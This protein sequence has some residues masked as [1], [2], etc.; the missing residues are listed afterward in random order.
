MEQN[1]LLAT[2][3]YI[4]PTRPELVHRPDLINKLNDGL[5]QSDLPKGLHFARK[6]TLIS[7]PAG[8]GKTTLVSE[9]IQAVR[10]D[11]PSVSIAWLS[12]DEGDNDLTRFLSYLIAALNASESLDH[13]FGQETLRMLQS[14]QP[15]S[16]DALLV[17]LINEI[18]AVR[19]QM[20]VIL[21]DY[22][23]IN[24]QTIHDA[25][26]LLIEHL[27]PQL[28]L[29]I[30]TRVDPPLPLARL[31]GRG[32][33]CEFRAVDLRFSLTEA[34]EFL[35]KVM[36]LHLATQDIS[37]LASRTE[38]WIAGL[39]LA[40]ISLQG[41]KNTSILIESFTG[42]HR[43]VMDY[44]VEEVLDQQSENVQTFLLQTSFLDRMSGSLCHA[45]T[46][47]QDSQ[48]ILERLDRA[49]LFIVPLDNKR[50]WYRYHHLFA[51]L[52]RQRLQQAQA[53]NL[54]VLHLRASQWYEQNGF[55]EQSIKHALLGE[56]P[57]RA[58]RLIESIAETLLMRGEII[59]LKSWVDSL[60]Q[61]IVHQ[62]PLLCLYYAGV[63]MLSGE[64]P[65]RI[66]TYLQYSIARAIP[67]TVS[68]GTLVLRALLALWQGDADQSITLGQHALAE[69]PD[70]YLFWR[71]IV[72]GN[73]GIAYMYGGRDID[74]AERMLQRAASMGERVG[75]VIGAVTALCNLAEVH[76][77]RGELRTAKEVYDR[78]L[79]LAVD[80]RGAIL[81]IGGMAITG[82][83][84][85]Q[86][87]WNKLREAEKLLTTAI[88][89][90]DE[91][92]PFWATEGYLVLARVKQS[93]GDIAS[94]NDAIGHAKK[95]AAKTGATELDD[96][97]VDATQAHLWVAQGQLNAAARWAKDRGLIAEEFVFASKE[98]RT[99][100]HS[101]YKLEYLTLAELWIG[102]G[103][104]G[105]ALKLLS[106]FLSESRSLQWTDSVIK[107]LTLTAIAHHQLGHPL[108][109]LDALSEA[110]I[111][112]KRGG[113]KRTFLNSG[114]HI[115]HLLR[116]TL[117]QGIAVDYVKQLLTAFGSDTSHPAE[118]QVRVELLS[119]RELQVLRLLR[120]HLTSAEIAQ[121]LYISAN[122]VRFHTKNIYSKLNVHSRSEAIQ[123]AQEL[124]LL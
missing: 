51:D 58:A 99:L 2:K 123:R 71:G 38:G 57:E 80:D 69:L 87:E 83:A 3:F 5:R 106:P 9:W 35:N 61:E 13:S 47:R 29:V 79:V 53:K 55:A 64:P 44:L 42:S 23:L 7:A 115:V 85:L 89:L 103:N 10:K 63:L 4:P 92:L 22:H 28:H 52:L 1:L 8:F 102:Q 82:I 120:T 73:L 75:S 114:P 20:I 62:H 48:A 119:D 81:P 18:L 54:P 50:Q 46:G 21:D 116:Q 34:A 67:D 109:A 15:P 17:P 25:L 101:L 33:L 65:S 45:V 36:G 72:T 77:I 108:Q 74:T 113:Y 11:V 124:G 60:P 41:H 117:T 19:D 6:L 105:W 110:L 90:T 98:N 39:Q 84:G 93:L 49:N 56:S 16:H 95:R 122:T 24:A 96:M 37:A 32:Q 88:D 31:R 104:S 26:I 70:Q 27:P 78:A 30:T 59:T 68:H 86:L 112:A 97:F 100:P 121:E 91:N 43:Y 40:A 76:L 118:R 12:L 111:H 107:I 14:P 94:A 66:R